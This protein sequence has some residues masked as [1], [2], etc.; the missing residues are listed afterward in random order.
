M[1]SKSLTRHFNGFGSGFTELRAKLD[2]DALLDFVTHRRQNKTRRRKSI[3]VK[4]MRVHS[5]MSRGR[6][7][8]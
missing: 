3:R 5:A 8:Q 1:F 7:M 2:A 4:I 6:L